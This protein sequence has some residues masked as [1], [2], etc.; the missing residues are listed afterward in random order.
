[1]ANKDKIKWLI[2][3]ALTALS[4]WIVLPTHVLHMRKP[5]PGDKKPITLGLD[6]AGGLRYVLEVDQSKVEGSVKDAQ[7]RAIKVIRNRI[8]AMGV[9]E[10]NIQS[11]GDS[12]IVV[13]LPGLQARDSDR[14]L[15]NIK[16]VAF[17]KFC[18]VHPKNDELIRQLFD[19]KQAPDGY[20]ISN[21]SEPTPDGGS[22]SF[23]C[24]LRDPTKG[25]TNLTEEA[26]REG[27]ATFHAPPGHSLLLERHANKRNQVYY[28]PY[29]IKTAPELKGESLSGA[30]YEYDQL[31]RPYVTLQLNSDAKTKFW[32]LTKRYAARGSENE[33]PNVPRY[34]AI[35]LDDNVISAPHLEDEI[36]NGQAIIRGDFTFDQV[37]DLALV[38][39]SGQLPAPVKVMS[40][41]VV[42]PALGADAIASGKRATIIGCLAVVIFMAGYYFLAGMV[43]NFA[44]IWNVLLL[45]VTLLV[46]GALLGMLDP[47]TTGSAVSLPTLTLPGIAGIV[48][49]IGMAVDANVLI[50]E[51]IREEQHLGR[52]LKSVLNAGYHKA[53]SA[54][55]DSHV[56]TIVSAFILF[57]LGSGTIRGFAVTLAAGIALSLYTS[58]VVTR[59]VFNLI[60]EHTNLKSIRMLELFK[61][62]PH[63]NFIGAWKI[64]AIFSTVVILGSWAMTLHRG[65]AVLGVEFTGGS[66]L[67]FVF[68]QKA[69]VAAIN[70]AITAA[71]ISDAV[72]RYQQEAVVQTGATAKEYLLVNSGSE[73]SDKIVSVLEKTFQAEGLKLFGKVNIGPKMSYELAQRS[74]FAVGVALLLM[75]V[76]IGIRF[77][78]PYAIG[79]IVSLLHD[80]LVAIGLYCALGE[81]LSLNIVAAVLTIIGY[82]INDTIVV[83]D[84]IR[85]NVKLARG[86]SYR[87]IANESINLSLG[88]TILTTSV[89]M[90]SVLALFL[91]GGGSLR[92]LT[93]CLLIG[94]TTGVYSTVY[95]ATPFVLL[96]HREKKVVSI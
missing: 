44:L 32:N 19:R 15:Q 75:A 21:M 52:D 30:G 59:M 94:M 8:D 11:E 85:E 60:Q 73:E 72:P 33:N 28:R 17:L 18:M 84:R 71:G 66:S 50:Y 83:F 40:T 81:Q 70:A 10:P 9:A 2:L 51:R 29:F 65:K 82:S 89:T 41:L 86:K 96:F 23:E 56:T 45:P 93:L 5:L 1:M 64:C 80:V 47:D 38:L 46:V 4:L 16:D 90:L 92:D 34:L 54:I 67:T 39:R 68:N 26:V 27:V 61:N 58:L 37:K 43:A 63:I 31:Q 36:P 87:E 6:L 74:I 7:A 12:R 76:Y 79:A 78:F 24:Y 20:T 62:V 57:W 48:L 77:E 35:V 49:T 53:F 22:R 42:D 14:A 13:E 55:F 3:L 25:N 91:F 69:P 88:R 95:V